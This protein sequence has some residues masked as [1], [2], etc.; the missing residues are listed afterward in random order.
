MLGRVV[1]LGIWRPPMGCQLFVDFGDA[2]NTR[3]ALTRWLPEIQ[4]GKLVR[5][6]YIGDTHMRCTYQRPFHRCPRIRATQGIQTR[7]RAHRYWNPRST[8]NKGNSCFPL[9]VLFSHQ[10]YRHLLRWKL[11]PTFSR[12]GSEDAC[13]GC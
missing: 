12:R 6:K 3:W 1:N 7:S 9:L 10:S 2:G 4:N 13:S 11:M 5:C 8:R